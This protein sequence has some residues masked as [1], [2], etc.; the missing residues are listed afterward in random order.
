DHPQQLDQSLL[1]SGPNRLC[2]R[3][4]SEDDMHFH[5]QACKEYTRWVFCIFVDG[6]PKETGIKDLLGGEVST[7]MSPVGPLWQASRM[8]R[9]SLPCTHRRIT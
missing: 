9:A 8:S 3:A 7:M 4:Q 2:A 6:G 5:T 1:A